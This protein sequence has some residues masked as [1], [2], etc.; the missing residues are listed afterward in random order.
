M[1][2]RPFRSIS[3]TSTSFAP[4]AVSET[5]CLANPPA[6]LLRYHAIVLSKNEAET[7]SMS[8]SPSISAATMERTSLA[9]L[10]ITLPAVKRRPFAKGSAF[11]NHST[12]PRVTE[13][14]STST[15]P[16]PS[17]SITKMVEASAL[18]LVMTCIV[19]AAEPSLSYHVT[20]PLPL[21]AETTSISPSESIS[22]ASTATA[23]FILSVITCF[24]K[25]CAPSF[26]YHAMVLSVVDEE[27][28]STSPSP[29]TSIANTELASAA[30]SVI[31]CFV[32][33]CAPSFSYHAM[34]LSVGDAESTSTSPSLST[35]IANTELTPNTE[36]A[37]TCF[38]PPS[39][40]QE[41]V[42]APLD[43]TIM[44]LYP[45]PSIS[46]AYK[47]AAPCAESSILCTPTATP[48]ASRSY[49]NTLLFSA[50]ATTTSIIPSLFMS[51]ARTDVALQFVAITCSMNPSE[52]SFS[53]HDTPDVEPVIMSTSPSPSMSIAKTLLIPPPES[54]ISFGAPGISV[55]HH[56]TSAN[57]SRILS[58]K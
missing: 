37:T 10:V 38:I 50:S 58:A 8:P 11:S 3:S 31:T 35:S 45:S 13:P 20:A 19:N 4:T 25:D 16:S 53:C 24:V 52:P 30:A 17:I 39:S 43:A 36:F 46:L 23:W 1:S 2:T 26:S 28:T 18:F 22:T 56:G 57:I 9:E 29:S 55:G 32:K 49:Q 27:S 5:T 47:D 48:E 7:T 51:A 40:Y 33:D 12:G 41:I 6:P 34:V 42:W 21:E 44:F 54:T 15:S 14:D